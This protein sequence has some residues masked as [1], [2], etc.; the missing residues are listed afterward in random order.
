M[1]DWECSGTLKC[2][3][4]YCTCPS[5]APYNGFECRNDSDSG[6]SCNSNA[7][8]GFLNGTVCIG[9]ANSSTCACRDP[10]QKMNT[11]TLE[12]VDREMY[13]PCDNDD[14]CMMSHTCEVMYGGL[15]L[16][17]D[18]SYNN[19]TGNWSNGGFN[20]TSDY[21][22][23]C[24][25][26]WDCSGTFKCIGSYCTCPSKAPY[27][28]VEC[29]NDS[30]SGISCNSNADCGFLNGTV[31]IG[32][33]NSST[34]ACRDPSQK[35]NTS[36]L[37][38]VD[39]EMYDPCDNDDDCMMSHTC[40]VMYGGLRLC[41]DESYNNTTGNWSNGGFNNTSDYYKSC[42][43]D[44]DCSGTFKCIGSYCTCPSKA[45][46][47]GFECRND[48]DSGITCNTNTDCGF[49]NGTVCI[50][51]ANRSTCACR[52]PSQKMNT[53]TFACVDR[54]LYDPCDNDDDCM[55]SHTCEVMYGGLRLCMDESYNN[56][57]GNWSN[58]G[59][60]NSSDYYKSCMS[61]WDCSGTFKC[62]GSYCTCPSKAPYNGF[63]C[64][65]DSDSG[66]SCNSNAD[67]GFLNGTVCIGT[68]NSST[69]A[70]RDP[71]QK[72]N[73]STLECVDREMYDPCDNDDD[74]MMSHTCEVMYGGLRLCMDESYNNTTGN[75]SNGGFNNTSDYYK[76]CMSDW[77]C[78]GTF[79]CI[80]S[81][82][83]CPS[84]AP[85][86]GFEC[87]NDSDSGIT[88]NT[89]TDCGFLNGTVCIG[90]ANRS[91]CACRDPSQKMNTSTFACVDRGLYDPCDNDDDCMMSHTCEVMYGG[92]RLCMDES[93]NN[94]AGNWSNGGFNNTSD[95]YKSCMSDWDCSGT[96]K[97]I[98]SYCTCPSKAPYNGFECRN[99]S[100]SGISCNSNADCGFLNGTVCIGTANSSTCACRDPSQ[101]M[102]TSTFACVDREMYDPCDNDDD[103]MMS[104][105]CEVMYGGL[106]LCMDESYNNTTG[107]WTNGGFNNTSD[108]Y[109][110]CMSDWDCSGTFKCIGSN[111]TC[112]S[113]APYNGVECRNDSDSGI[114]CF[115]NADCGFLNGTVCIGTA[116][117]STCA[118]RD[119]SQKMNTST[120]ACVDRGLY[121]P[122]DNDDDCMMS[123]TCEVMYGGLRLCMDES[124]SNTTGNWT[125]DGL[126][127]TENWTPGPN[128][129]GNWTPGPNM[130]GN[131]TTGSNMTGNVNTFRVNSHCSQFFPCG[132]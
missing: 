33:A 22:K 84:K 74:C 45:P 106:R 11:S 120:F 113:K 48:S 129:T 19:T 54:G 64:R 119:P 21:Y 103:C 73:T 117:R 122:C 99:D 98:G 125:N 124:F 5:K 12:C 51:T 92:L 24:M 17:M 86:N 31:C 57:T 76:S 49:L 37:E 36:T 87:R 111:C 44:W 107:N 62:I 95:Y 75:W 43:S 121:D 50:G 128:M 20:N 72:M 88:C 105:T 130:T 68:A 3:G 69:C 8:C 7:D 40:E 26:D 93:Y 77:D 116:N 115:S 35:M 82:C 80:G 66:I 38:C 109:K 110:S 104:H 91:T 81:Y 28:G 112:P 56:T 79:K 89:N 39:R 41:M 118:C 15:R 58:G 114:S 29:R 52:D 96:F 59:F 27:N 55:M 1:S 85:Y 32:T 10:S 100:D 65:N 108:Y 101:K 94:T 70:C 6:I 53:S 18:E 83:T 23:S 102:N 4:S 16:C 42:M 78:S 131:W 2:I 123:H 14:D 97:C 34:C 30:D 63:E 47:N 67:C 127:N 9:T 46:Y 61:D 90:T 126:N 132:T 13:D 25:S 71:S 60:N